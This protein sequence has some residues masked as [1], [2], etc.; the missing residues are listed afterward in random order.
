MTHPADS[1]GVANAQALST[2]TRKTSWVAFT[3]ASSRTTSSASSKRKSETTATSAVVRTLPATA[4]LTLDAAGHRLEPASRLVGF[5]AVDDVTAAGARR[6][7]G[8]RGEAAIEGEQPEA[9]L[10]E[11]GRE[12]DGGHGPGD[13]RRQRRA[14]GAAAG[15]QRRVGH[16]QHRGGARL[17]EL[18]HDQ[19]RE[20]GQRRLRP[21]DGREAVAGLPVAQADEVEAGAVGAAAVVAGDPAGQ[22]AQHQQLDLGDLV[23]IDERGGGRGVG[24]GIGTSATTSAMT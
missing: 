23:E 20:V 10:E 8:H 21:V 1:G 9:V 7:A 2:S 18:A 12:A 11:G 5:E 4:A 19:R 22:P 15:R 3:S 13:D 14:A 6:H 17:I 16:R 24:H